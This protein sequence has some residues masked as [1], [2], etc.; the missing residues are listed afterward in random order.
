MLSKPFKPLTIGKS[1]S[2][3]QNEDFA[4]PTA[5]RRKL[6]P[7]H[8]NA[9]SIEPI[10]P[11]SEFQRA[12][13]AEIRKRQA[14]KDINNP[15]SPLIPTQPTNSDESYFSVLW[16]SQLLLRRFATQAADINS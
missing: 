5:K 13:V 10:P 1:L 2:T 11:A 14:L 9:V 7:P 12:N 8:D 6:S 4:T 15:P 3:P 16:Y